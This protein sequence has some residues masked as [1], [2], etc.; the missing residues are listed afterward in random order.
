M[1]FNVGDRVKSNDGGKLV[2]TIVQ[3]NDGGFV[4]PTAIAVKFDEGQDTTYVSHEYEHVN[5]DALFYP[6]EIEH[7]NE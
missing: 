2:G 5:Y 3:R 1:E 7:V 4:F 6:E